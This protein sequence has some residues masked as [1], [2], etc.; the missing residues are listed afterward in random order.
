[1]ALFDK[2]ALQRLAT[3]LEDWEQEEGLALKRFG[4]RRATHETESHIPVKRVY[5]PA[6]IPDFDFERDCGMPGAPP[7]TRGAHPLGYR[8]QPFA[9]RPY[10]GFGTAEESNQRLKETLDQL[11][12][13]KACNIILDLPTAYYGIDADDPTARGEVGRTGVSINSIEDMR[14]L[15]VGVDPAKI[16]ITFNTTGILPLCFYIAMAEERGIKRDQLRGSQLNNPLGSYVSTGGVTL[17]HPVEAI[18]ELVDEIEFCAHQMPRWNPLSIGGYELREAGATP[19][20]ELA[21]MFANAIAYAEGCLSRGLTADQVTPRF[22]FYFSIGNNFFE[23]IAKFRASR[24][25]WEKLTRERFGATTPKARAFRVHSQTS[26]LTLTAEQPLNN[27]V[28]TTMQSLAAVLGG[29]NSLHTDAYDEA[30]CL[31]SEEGHLVATRTQQIILEESGAGDTIDPLAGSYFVEHLTNV[32][33]ERVW[34]YMAEIESRGGMVAAVESGW[35]QAEVD[36]E[37]LKHQRAVQSGDKVVVGYNRYRS[38]AASDAGVFRVDPQYEVKQRQRLADLRQRRDGQKVA[39]ALAAVSEATRSHVNL[40]EPC[41]AAARA[42]ATL[43]EIMQAMNAERRD[44]RNT[45]MR[46]KQQSVA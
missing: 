10:L 17:P 18:R 21:F 12:D 14:D 8:S 45:F 22:L 24:R 35:A 2:E 25:I 36:R 15:F 19:V 20:Q 38:E 41:I 39:S 28:R 23:E 16:S 34:K 33:E 40:M 31:P 4:E 11:G 7:F 43:G 37:M 27:I 1:M 13:D 26:G 3:R 32:I 42:R 44:F 9:P 6:D 46:I 29:T 5:T 30:L